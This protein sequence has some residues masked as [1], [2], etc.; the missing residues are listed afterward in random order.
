V[1]VNGAVV[2][3][4]GASLP[5]IPEVVAAVKKAETATVG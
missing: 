3:Q 1:S 4:K 5:A 2:A